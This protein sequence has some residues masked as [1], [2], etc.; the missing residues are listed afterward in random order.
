MISL[1]FVDGT[2]GEVGHSATMRFRYA[3]TSSRWYPFRP[4]G[5]LARWTTFTGDLPASSSAA[6]CSN[7]AFTALCLYPFNVIRNSTVLGVTAPGPVRRSTDPD[8]ASRLGNGA[9]CPVHSCPFHQRSEFGH[10]GSENQ[11]SCVGPTPVRRSTRLIVQRS[12]AVSAIARSYRPEPGK[13]HTVEALDG[14][15][16]TEVRLG[17]GDPPGDDGL[18]QP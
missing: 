6:I 11:P 10:H 5:S 13:C 4:S 15:R 1:G 12:I 17:Q 9:V 8:S 18:L 3:S 7:S 2:T 14:P 16:L